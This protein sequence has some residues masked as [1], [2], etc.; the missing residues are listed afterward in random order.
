M[1]VLSAV[2]A[3][4]SGVRLGRHDR[5]RAANRVG[6]AANTAAL[7]CYGASWWNRR[8]GR[9]LRGVTYGMLN[10]RGDGRRYLGGH[11]MQELGIGVDHTAFETRPESGRRV[12]P[13]IS[14]RRRG[15]RSVTHRSSCSAIAGSRRPR[16][17]VPASNADGRRHARR[18]LD[19]LPVAPERFRVADGGIEAVRQRCPCLRTTAA[20]RAKTSRSGRV[21]SGF[22]AP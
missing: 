13:A 16:R 5:T 1:G 14:L 18:R 21:G 10:D 15:V 9:Q 17:S 3:I 11:L 12:R 7:A 6:A 20:S 4:L 22:P 2:P 19:R 8:Q